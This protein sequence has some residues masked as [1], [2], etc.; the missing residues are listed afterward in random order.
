MSTATTVAVWPLL[1]HVKDEF[2]NGM[3]YDPEIGIFI[4]ITDKEMHFNILQEY[5]GRMQKKTLSW[6]LINEIIDGMFTHEYSNLGRKKVEFYGND[7][8]CLFKYFVKNDD[9]QRTY[10]WLILTLNLICFTMITISY[11]YIYITSAKSSKLLEKSP[12]NN[13][14]KNRNK[15]LQQKISMI[16]VTDFCCWIPFMIFCF[17]HTLAVI[18][19]TPWY[20]LFSIIIL[21]INSVINPL[22]YD[23][24]TTDSVRSSIRKIISIR[25][26]STSKIS[27]TL[28]DLNISN[29]CGNQNEKALEM[30]DVVPKKN[31]AQT[32]RSSNSNKMVV[33]ND[34]GMLPDKGKRPRRSKIMVSG[35]R[36]ITYVEDG[37]RPC[38][39]KT[40]AIGPS[41]V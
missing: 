20:S 3:K 28:P 7:A 16:V 32:Q 35:E 2:V 38:S 37:E 5:Y 21:P 11:M 9:P 33:S 23:N 26:H 12:G 40:I 6:S 24:A 1:P 13:M 41:K 4:G 39:S 15:K 34:I 31:N 25:K 22:L 14:I 29:S 27:S 17:L 18:D 30:R 10:V 36:K 8:V 19:A